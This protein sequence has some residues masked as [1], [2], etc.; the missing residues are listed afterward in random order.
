MLDGYKKRILALADDYGSRSHDDPVRGVQ[1]LNIEKQLDALTR[2]TAALF[3]PAHLLRDNPC[4]KRADFEACIARLTGCRIGD[5]M[6]E[7]TEDRKYKNEHIQFL[8][9]LHNFKGAADLLDN[10]ERTDHE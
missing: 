3:R 8:W 9:R 5:G 7:V 1:A 10:I 6:L 4:L 2:D